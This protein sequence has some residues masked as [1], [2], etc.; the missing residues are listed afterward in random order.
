ME[1]LFDLSNFC[2]LLPQQHGHTHPRLS[3]SR[4]GDLTMN[5]AFRKK[6]GESREFRALYRNDGLQILLFPYQ[7]PNVSFSKVSGV[8]KNRQLADFL[9]E[10]GFHFPLRYDLQWDEENQ[11]WVGTCQEMAAS[12][13]PPS[14]KAPGHRGRAT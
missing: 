2:E 6:Q 9:N 11:V 3:V 14:R 12:L 10:L 7:E 5:E 13:E 8:A 1:M 4:K